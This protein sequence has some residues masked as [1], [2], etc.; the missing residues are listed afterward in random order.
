[1]SPGIREFSE[2]R[3]TSQRTQDF[4]FRAMVK[5]YIEQV[6]LKIFKLQSL[7]T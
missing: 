6:L 4:G 3:I 2:M 7:L 1:M 5:N